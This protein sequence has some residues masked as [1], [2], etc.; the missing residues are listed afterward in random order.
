MGCDP[1]F[2]L[3]VLV[4]FLGCV[5]AQTKRGAWGDSNE[6]K[7]FVL[8]QP[9][10]DRRSRPPLCQQPPSRDAEAARHNRS[11]TLFLLKDANASVVLRTRQAKSND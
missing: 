10:T 9:F 1:F 4:N 6:C 7:V 2:L 3:S 5:P 11:Q 8:G